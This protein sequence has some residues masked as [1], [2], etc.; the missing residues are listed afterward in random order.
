MVKGRA[1]DQ[2]LKE[3]LFNYKKKLNKSKI[4]FYYCKASNSADIAETVWGIINSEVGN[5]NGR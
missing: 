5:K 4:L 1:T 2:K 3:N